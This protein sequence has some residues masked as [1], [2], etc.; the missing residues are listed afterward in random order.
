MRL[1]DRPESDQ[2]EDDRGGGGFGGRHIVGGGLGL[3]SSQS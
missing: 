3:L 2:V 1:D